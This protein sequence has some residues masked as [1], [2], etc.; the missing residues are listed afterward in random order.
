MG[1]NYNTALWVCSSWIKILQMDR[2]VTWVIIYDQVDCSTMKIT[3]AQE[4]TERGGNANKAG[5]LLFCLTW[6]IGL[7]TVGEFTFSII[8]FLFNLYSYSPQ[9][10]Q[11]SIPE[12]EQ[13]YGPLDVKGESVYNSDRW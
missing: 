11:F 3:K 10:Q 5:L 9:I 12:A 4:I 13:N 8:A 2:V 7:R 6:G 1:A